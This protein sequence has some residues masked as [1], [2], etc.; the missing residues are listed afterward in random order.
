MLR[1]KWLQGK[2]VLSIG[3]LVLIFSPACTKAQTYAI[4][5]TT[6]TFND[7]SRSRPIE[8]KIFYPSD[9]GGVDEV[10]ASGQFP[11][12]VLGHGFLMS[13]DSYQIYWEELVPEGHIVC[14]PTT[15]SGPLP[16]HG[17]FGQ[18]ISFIIAAMQEE[19][20][21]TNSLFYN[22]V[23]SQAVVMGHSMGGGSAVLSASASP[24]VTAMVNFAAAETNP[25]AISAASSITVPSLIFS[26][27]DDCVTPEA[28][29]Q[30]LMYD[31]LASSCKYQISI[32]NGAH[33]LFANSNAVCSLGETFCNP[34]LSITRE[35]QLD[36]VISFLKP[37]LKATLLNDGIAQ[38]E[39]SD[40]LQASTRVNI[41]QSCIATNTESDI[42]QDQWMAYYNRL[43]GSLSLVCS[44]AVLGGDVEVYTLT[45]SRVLKS[46]IR[47]Y[48]SSYEISSWAEG[49]YV[50]LINGVK[51][52]KAHQLVIR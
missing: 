33:C 27:N 42:S 49:V 23:S 26:G 52:P 39:F 13:W 15:E 40:S 30:D 38:T 44:D 20:L 36:I 19:G 14:L 45:G 32:I 43:E 12:L 29:N 47:T 11:V 5:S 10:I 17:D 4:G 1:M 3:T 24:L 21:N 7:A 8:T 46:E 34:T 48:N 25:S 31:N 18:D 2:I 41:R 16:S 37:W 28:Q 51:K 50:I 9:I 22:A 6:I 35:E